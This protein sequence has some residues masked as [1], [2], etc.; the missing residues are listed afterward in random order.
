MRD[1]PLTEPVTG[2]SRF[3]RPDAPVQAA[4]APPSYPRFIRHDPEV[5]PEA[6]PVAETAAADTATE[7]PTPLFFKSP[8]E[9][10]PKPD[11]PRPLSPWPEAP[12]PEPYPPAPAAMPDPP[13]AET[14]SWTG[15]WIAEPPSAPEPP[16]PYGP[17]PAPPEYVAEPQVE[18]EAPVAEVVEDAEVVEPEAEVV[19]ADAEVIEADA[20]VVEDASRSPSRWSR[21]R[22]RPR[23]P[24]P[25]HP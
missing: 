18:A 20:E 2:G 25:R 7:P 6:I 22:H 14:G 21:L 1:K 17:E 12:A 16:V 10:T 19:E 13:P 15:S 24:L 3:V 23:S 11:E 8:P 9:D 5:T 4:S